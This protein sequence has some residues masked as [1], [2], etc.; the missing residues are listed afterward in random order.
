[1]KKQ[2]FDVNAEF[3][4]V[5]PAYVAANYEYFELL[6]QPRHLPDNLSDYVSKIKKKIACMKAEFLL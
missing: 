2:W 6:T 5:L 3:C 1:M 4:R